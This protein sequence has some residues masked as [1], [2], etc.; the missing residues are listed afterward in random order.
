[1]LCKIK[2]KARYETVA[3]TVD[4]AIPR[5]SGAIVHP[6]RNMATSSEQVLIQPEQQRVIDIAA[7]SYERLAREVMLQRRSSGWKRVPASP[8]HCAH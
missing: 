3:E 7:V 5:T 6:G 4:R 8:A 2:H 1:M